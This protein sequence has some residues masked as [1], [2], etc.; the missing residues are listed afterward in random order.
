MMRKSMARRRAG[1]GR[2]PAVLQARIFAGRVAGLAESAARALITRPRRALAGCALIAL[3][4]ALV[5]LDPAD[6]PAPG[7]DDFQAVML[8]EPLPSQAVP[9]QHV[10]EPEHGRTAASPPDDLPAA[11]ATLPTPPAAADAADWQLVEVRPGQTLERIFREL[12]LSAREL[13]DVVHLNEHTRNLA[14]IRPGDQFGFELDPE[15]GL[16]ALRADFDEERWLI[17]EQTDEGLNSRFLERAMDSRIVEASGIISSSLFNAAKEAGLSDGMT[18]RLA[19]IFGWDIDFALDIRSGDRFALIYEE[20][21]RDGEYLRDG[22]ILAARF[23]NQGD[24]FEAIRFDA[25]NGPDYFAP[26]GRPMRKAF[27]RAPLNFTRV[28]SNFNPRRFH[29]ITQRLRPHNGTDYGAPTGTPVWA[30]GDG[31]VI[32]SAYNNANGNYVFIQHGN[33]VITRYLHLHRR[34]VNVGDRVRQGQTIGTVGAT[35]MA[36]GPHLHYEFLV[37]G[38]HRNPRTVD[39]PTAEPLPADLMEDFRRAGE[40]LLAQLDELQGPAVLLAQREQARCEQAETD[41]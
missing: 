4:V 12:G 24:A 26:D 28:T 13:H 11:E 22:P 6:A 34:S 5:A 40:P 32:R 36:T 16:A 17:I 3:G 21:W 14:R 18:M 19:N 2:G 10:G 1:H 30:A 31:R 9:G 33:N 23:V 20:I 37:N 35:G 8:P 29:P 41:C 25:G 27:L 15:G 39:L 38:A 7:A